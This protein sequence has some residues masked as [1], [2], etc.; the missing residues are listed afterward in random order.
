L[1]QPL[2]PLRYYQE[3]LVDEARQAFRAGHRSVLVQSP[4]G[5]GKTFVFLTLLLA[6]LDRGTSPIAIIFH[7]RHLIDMAIDIL[8]EYEIE[9]GVIARGYPRNPT[10]RIQLCSVGTLVNRL[11]RYFPAPY[12][13]FRFLVV[14]EA[15]HAPAPSWRR[16]LNRFPDARVIG[17]TAT[18]KRLDGSGLD[19]LFDVLVLGPSIRQLERAGFLAQMAVYAPPLAADLSRLR[20]VRGDFEQ[21]SLA[22]LMMQQKLLGE[23]VEHWIKHVVE[24]T[25]GAQPTI[26]FAVDVRHSQAMAE[27]FTAAGFRARHIDANTPGDQRRAV[28]AGLRDGATQILCNCGIVSE[29]LDV[30][31]AR[32]LVMVRPTQSDALYLQMCGR[33]ARPNAGGA[34]SIVLDHAGNCLRLGRPN[35]DRTWTLAGNDEP[36]QPAPVRDCPECGAVIPLSA[37]VCP[38]CGAILE[39][40]TPRRNPAEKQGQLQLLPDEDLP[41]LGV[42]FQRDIGW[43]EAAE[44]RQS[45]AM[46]LGYVCKRRDYEWGWLW[47]QL[48]ERGL[49]EFYRPVRRLLEGAEAA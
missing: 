41:L 33:V 30:P 40:E 2:P 17:V 48:D 9:F 43:A 39:T 10:A 6:A 45:L 11:A 18:P 15:H 37:R 29:G 32:A 24:A 34:K 1:S 19:D 5:S 21:R 8:T 3:R 25:G 47:H 23:P 44:D 35:E 27:R 46:R 14:D 31:V 13:E 36:K 26:L 28:I 20:Q 16:I 38:E 12:A 49:G 42:N 4:T 7:R 22:D